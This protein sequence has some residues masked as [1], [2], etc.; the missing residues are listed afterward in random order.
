MGSPGFSTA[1]EVSLTMLL[2]SEVLG[3][4]WPVGWRSVSPVAGH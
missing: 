1:Q 2:P 4:E 3:L